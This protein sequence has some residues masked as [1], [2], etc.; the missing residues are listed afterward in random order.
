M[1]PEEKERNCKTCRMR[2]KNVFVTASGHYSSRH[3]W[4]CC[5]LLCFGPNFSLFSFAHVISTK[6]TCF[7]KAVC[8]PAQNWICPHSFNRLKFCPSSPCCLWLLPAH[9]NTTSETRQWMRVP[10]NSRVAF[11]P[12]FSHSGVKRLVNICLKPGCCFFK[13]LSQWERAALLLCCLHHLEDVTGCS[14][15]CFWKHRKIIS[16]CSGRLQHHTSSLSCQTL[17]MHYAS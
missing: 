3:I 7:I 14:C 2:C 10:S 16:R 1:F 13:G 9:E 4:S 11:G 15:K 6:T 5:W 17:S 8:I 12:V